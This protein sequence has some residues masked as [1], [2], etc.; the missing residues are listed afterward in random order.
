M[1]KAFSY[2]KKEKLKSRK[3]LEKVFSKGKSFLVFPVKIFYAEVEGPL[4]FPIKVGVGVS[5]RNFKKAVQRNRVKR[6]LRE[7]YRLNKAPLHEYMQ[8]NG[9]RAMIFFL[10]IDKQLPQ[11]E[12]LQTKMSLIIDKLL[13]KISENTTENT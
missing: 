2:G 9:K 1:Q 10:Y 7:S 11:L 12:L 13:K 3:L 6:L 4:D 5:S 8:V